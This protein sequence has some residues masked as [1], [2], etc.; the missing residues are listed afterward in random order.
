MPFLG[1]SKKKDVE[2]LIT[3][4]PRTDKIIGGVT[5]LRK[6]QEP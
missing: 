1:V 2:E 3:H 6:S 4:V 5:W